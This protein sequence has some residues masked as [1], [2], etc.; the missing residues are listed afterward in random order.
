MFNS[1][2]ARSRAPQL[3]NRVGINLAGPTLLAHGTPDQ[4]AALA[5]TDHDR[6]GDLV[7]ALQRTGSGFGPGWAFRQGRLLP[8]QSVTG[9][10]L[11]SGQ[12]VWTSY[13]QFATLGTVPGPKRSRVRRAPGGSPSSR[14][15]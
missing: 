15:T 10:W 7:P 9:G 3:V 2:Y 14:W 5:A 6:R 4:L 12:K 1:E 11:V 13:A 8:V